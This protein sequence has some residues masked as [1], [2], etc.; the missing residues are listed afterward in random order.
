[1]K[2][3]IVYMLLLLTALFSCQR[4]EDSTTGEIVFYT[5]AQAMLNCGP[6]DVVVYLNGDN[7]GTLSIPYVSDTLPNL[8]E[9]DSSV[10]IVE[11]EP[12][13][14][15]YSACF[16]CGDSPHNCDGNIIIVAGKKSYVFLNIDSFQAEPNQSQSP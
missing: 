12:G 8:Q 10:L 3:T 15:T 1:M 6:F 13:H 9:S 14:Y 11:K 7:A 2:R 5:N 4:D 16:S